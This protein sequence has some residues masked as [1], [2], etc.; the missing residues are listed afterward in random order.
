MDVWAAAMLSF[1]AEP[2]V[3][4]TKDSN[5]ECIDEFD[6]ALVEEPISYGWVLL[7]CSVASRAGVG[8]LRADEAGKLRPLHCAAL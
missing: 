5:V 3:G 7:D 6:D 4:G 8:I 2:V 1:K